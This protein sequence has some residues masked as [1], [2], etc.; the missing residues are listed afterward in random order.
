MKASLFLMLLLLSLAASATTEITL[1][2][3]AP[4]TKAS[5]HA[6][7]ATY[8]AAM[9]E[10]KTVDDIHAW[11]GQC[12]TYDMQRALMLSE[13]SKKKPEIF[14]PA[15]LYEKKSGVCIDLARFAVE[16]VRTLLPT[17]EV[18]Y[19]MIEFEPVT[20]NGRTLRRHWLACYELDGKSYIFADTKRPANIAGPYDKVTDF[21]D[22]YGVYRQRKIMSFKLL[23]DFRA[24]KN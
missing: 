5:G 20:I 4:A 3:E 14:M 22:E 7:P 15:E 8:V 21:I 16:T 23:D 13:N 10:W 24:K 2:D 17:T 1:T 19:L 18:Q 11:I 12:F 6:F 9:K